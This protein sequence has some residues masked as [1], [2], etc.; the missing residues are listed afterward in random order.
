MTSLECLVFLV[1]SKQGLKTRHFIGDF[2]TL[3][4]P[5]NKLTCGNGTFSLGFKCR[6]HCRKQVRIFGINGG[7]LRQLQGTDKRLFQLGHK[8][9]WTTE[10]G[11]ASAYGLSAGKS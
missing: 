10:K 3:G 7:F 1:C 5:T 11:N 8:V 9:K 2:Y 4:E 6:A